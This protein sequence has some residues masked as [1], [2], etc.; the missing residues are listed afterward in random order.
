MAEKKIIVNN[1][2]QK[3]YEYILTKPEGNLEDLKRTY[4]F[5]PAFSP[6]KMLQ[7]G[8][9]GGAYFKKEDIE[10]FP[11]NWFIGYKFS[12]SPDPNLNYFKVNSGLSRKE[13][14]D[15]GWIKG[16]DLHG[17][18]IWYCRTFLGRRSEHDRYQCLRW[19]K[20]NRHLIQLKKNCSPKD[21][22]C[23]PVQRQSLLHWSYDAF[24]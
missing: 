2:L 4:H 12:E 3:N 16:D 7:Y 1:S 21:F 23:R 18:F 9:F 5:D 24:Y 20:F 22:K 10:E 14:Q 6:K 17:W 15:R 19:K 8:V 13:W 11:K